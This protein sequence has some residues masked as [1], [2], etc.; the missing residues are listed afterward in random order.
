[1]EQLASIYP[2]LKTRVAELS[3]Q[4]ITYGTGTPFGAILILPPPLLIAHS[5]TCWTPLARSFSPL[6]LRICGHRRRGKRNDLTYVQ[7]FRSIIREEDPSFSPNCLFLSP[8][9]FFLDLAQMWERYFMKPALAC[10]DVRCIRRIFLNIA[11]AAHLRFS[12][13]LFT[14][15]Q[16][17]LCKLSLNPS[18]FLFSLQL[19]TEIAGIIMICL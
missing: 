19:I 2:R 4:R 5:C 1:M 17:W 13:D 10:F 8:R 9:A 6:W 7:M 15:A 12:P 3:A 18:I 16:V 11:L 14:V